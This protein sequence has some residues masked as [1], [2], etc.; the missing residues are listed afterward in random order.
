MLRLMVMA[1][2]PLLSSTSSPSA[3]IAA[4]RISMRVPITSAS[5]SRITP[6]SSGILISRRSAR[7]AAGS[8]SLIVRISP[9]GGRTLMATVVRPRIMTPSISACPP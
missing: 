2:M 8:G 7:S 9:D 1:T 5:Y 4:E 3:A 6:R